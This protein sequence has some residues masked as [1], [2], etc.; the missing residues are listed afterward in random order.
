MLHVKN[1][2]I[3]VCSHKK[4]ELPTQDYYLPIQVGAAMANEHW[5]IQRDDEGDNISNKNKLYSELTAHYWAWKNL[6]D[7][8]YVGLAHYRRYLK[9]DSEEQIIGLLAN[10]DIILPKRLVL[11]HSNGDNLSEVLTRE[12]VYILVAVIKKISP[13]YIRDV[14]NYLCKSNKNCCCNMFITNNNIF[15]AYSE[16]LFPILEETEKYV[17]LSGYT[18]LRRIFGY[19]S[20]V[21]LPAFVCHNNYRVKYL[22]MISFPGER[23]ETSLKSSIRALTNNIS[24]F[25]RDLGK[26]KKYH[27]LPSTVTSMKLDNID[28]EY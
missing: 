18:R 21:L 2:K 23:R 19:F 8:K 16:W 17:R 6:H 14:E 22:E 27:P 20:E 11:P 26:D 9:F 25:L 1:L 4:V 15:K 12:D 28:L 5:G 3:L 7:I 24:Y 10:Y 13:E